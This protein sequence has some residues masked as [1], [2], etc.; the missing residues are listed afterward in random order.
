MKLGIIGLGTVGEG[1]LEILTKEKKNI[2]SKGAEVEVKYA[3]DLNIDRDFSFEFNK[4]ILT[5]N[6]KTILNDD[7]VETIVELIG[8]EGLAKEIVLEAIRKG[9]NVITANKALIAKHSK[10]IFTLASKRGVNLYYEASVGGGIPIINPLQENL[11]A[12][13]IIGIRGII[14]GTANYILTEMKEKNLDFDTVLKDA[15]KKGYAEADPT[16]DIEGIDTAHKICILASLAYNQTVDFD[17]IPISGITKIKPIDIHLAEKLGYNIKLIASAKK[18]GDKLAIQVAPTLVNKGDLLSNVHGVFNAV[19]VEGDY[20]GTTLFYGRG[21]GR[22]ATASAVVSDIVKA[23]V[24][25]KYKERH[26][27]NLEKEATLVKG[28]DLS[29]DYYI[30]LTKED[31]SNA[32]DTLANEKYEEDG[33]VVLLVKNTTIA[34]LEKAFAGKEYTRLSVN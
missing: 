14:N 17:S 22:E 16:Y 34:N 3:C 18:S 19:E 15:M 28:E 8:G 33:S 20:V 21:A 24:N 25:C 6:Y 23:A 5:K 12:N 13:N 4:N 1:V 11:V 26:Y 29:G 32:F 10:E 2:G 7:E 30:R 31:Y 27:F 9:K